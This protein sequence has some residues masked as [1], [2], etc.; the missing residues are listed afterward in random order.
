MR[1]ILIFILFALTLNL[2]AQLVL[3]SI[4]SDNM[5][6]QRDIKIP[7][8][9]KTA[10]EAKVIVKFHGQKKITSADMDGNW[11]LCLSPI[12]VDCN[13]QK[14]LIESDGCQ[15]TF[16]NILV[17][18]VWFC[19]GQSNMKLPL[20]EVNEGEKYIAKA[21]DNK[22]RLYQAARFYLRPYECDNC[23]GDWKICSSNTVKFF[24]AAGYFFGLE[25]REKLNIPIGLIEADFGG[26]EIEAWMNSNNLKKWPVYKKE[27]D[28]LAKYKNPQK[29]DHLRKKEKKE[30]FKKF[31]KTDPGFRENWMAPNIDD[32]DWNVMNL[33]RAWDSKYLNGHTGTVWYRKNI[34]F[35]KKWQKKDIVI[36]LGLIKGYDFIWFNG[37]LVWHAL[38]SYAS[39]WDRYIYIPWNEIKTGDNTLV[40]CNLSESGSAGPRGPK[41]LM[42]VYLKNSPTN[43]IPLDREWKCKKGYDG[44]TFPD[45]P[46]SLTLN[47]NT[48]SIQ[49]DVMIHPI[50]PY[51][52]RGAIRYC[53]TRFAEL[54]GIRGNR[55]GIMPICMKIYLLR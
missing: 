44:K 11:K 49:Y 7:V 8:W 30:L 39:W 9:G 34:T 35:P 36:S 21:N 40:V 26:T 3:P 41:K 2:S 22:I 51:A 29:F 25:L 43:Y 46:V 38:E 54:Y 12:S 5:V 4:F 16:T 31:K 19:S 1:K 45:F 28:L 47:Q 6:L 33:P 27:L 24:S 37:K 52:I 55:T 48:K 14:M 32:S 18:E 15:L 10:P 13:P 20:E 23:L 50:L 53:L 42:K 17:G